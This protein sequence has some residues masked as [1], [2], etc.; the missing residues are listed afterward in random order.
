MNRIISAA[1]L[2]LFVTLCFRQLAYAKFPFQSSQ[3]APEPASLQAVAST[4]DL[5]DLVLKTA[6]LSKRLTD[7]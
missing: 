5:A 7:L 1:I 4:P 3:P 2:V 6:E